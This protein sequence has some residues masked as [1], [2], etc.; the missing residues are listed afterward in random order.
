MNRN[1]SIISISLFFIAGLVLAWTAQAFNEPILNPPE[2]NIQAPILT[3]GSDL[4]TR[5]G[6]LKLSSQLNT[7]GSL[8]SLGEIITSGNLNVMLNGDEQFCLGDSCI[9]GWEPGGSIGT[10][11]HLSPTSA[12]S[13]FIHIQGGITFQA[14]DDANFA[15]HSGAIAPTLIDTYGFYGLSSSVVALPGLSYG[16]LGVAAHSGSVS[17]DALAYG[18]FG[19]NNGN[20]N[21]YA[22]YFTGNVEITAGSQLCL[23]EEDEDPPGDCRTSWPE[24]SGVNDYLFL[25]TEYPTTLQTGI[26]AVYG[27][28]HF[29]SAVLGDPNGH[30]PEITCGDGVC[31]E[32]TENPID[33]PADCPVISE[34]T[35][36]WQTP[37]S[38]EFT[39]TSNWPMYSVV[40]HGLTEDYGSKLADP[41]YRISH[42]V[43]VDNIDSTL[44]YHYRVGGATQ[45]SGTFLF[46]G[47]NFLEAGS[48]VDETPPIPITSQIGINLHLPDGTIPGDEEYTLLGWTHPKTD[49][50]EGINS[51]FS[52]FNIY[53][54]S[55]KIGESLIG[56]YKDDDPALTQ[57]ENYYYSISALDNNGNESE[58]RS[59]GFHI[60]LLCPSDPFCVAND[61]PYDYCCIFS[62]HGGESVNVCE[63]AECGGSSPIMAKGDAGGLR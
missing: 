58:W 48:V 8:T 39:W 3:G 25:Q 27:S 50:P 24:G 18:I 46:S 59:R 28:S 4:Q 16:V 47:D 51:G 49:L 35:A 34:I 26:T 30:V 36:E 14:A 54:N 42:S 38:A 13:D 45:G 61:T 29:L 52:H 19:G 15:L 20:P 23:L 33:C 7:S 43:L 21:A 53:R 56:G 44:D 6:P 5:W 31:T 60:N 12:D 55:V 10:I 41:V 63:D 11:L 62:N 32:S 17:S 9:N 22:G 40:E 2:G 57:G 1:I 37:T